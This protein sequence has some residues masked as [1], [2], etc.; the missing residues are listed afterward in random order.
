MIDDSEVDAFLEHYGVKGMRWGVRKGD[1]DFDRK[2]SRNKK[3]AVGAG[4]V[5]VAAGLVTAGVIL[6]N[7]GAFVLAGSTIK[8]VATAA[9]KSI[10]TAAAGSIIRKQSKPDSEAVIK[11]KMI[12]GRHK[13]L[14]MLVS[15]N[16]FVKWDDDAGTFVIDANEGYNQRTGDIGF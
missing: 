15:D 7:K 11:A 13:A 1:P 10:A 6:Q 16:H 5:A 3:I 9:A 14:Q 12:Q 2:V 4:S 8:P